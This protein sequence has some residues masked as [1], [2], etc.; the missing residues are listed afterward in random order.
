MTDIKFALRAFAKTPGFTIVVVLTLALGV[1]ATTAIFSVVNAVLLEP[2]PFANA[3]RLVV[4]RVSMPDYKDLRT[5]V[6]AFED[7]GVWGTNIYNLRLK[8]NSEQI[9]GAVVSS[10]LLSLLGVEPLLGRN[11]TAEDGQ[12]N[13]VV[14][15]FGLWQSRFG[16]DP[17]VLGRAIDLS[18]ISYTVVGVA[19]S[20]FSFPASEFKVWVPIDSIDR[21]A[22]VQANNRG[23]R[24]F[25]LLARLKPD[26]TLEQA[27]A[28]V[29]AQSVALGKAYPAT[30]EN[31][32]ITVQSLEE[33]L[34]GESK[35]GLNV[36]LVTV[37]L[38]L[39]IACAN[40]ANLMLART[41]TRER[42]L[43]IRAALGAGRA[44][45][46]RQVLTESLVLAIAG[47]ALGLLVAAWGVDALPALLADRLP[48]A[49]TIRLNG[50]VLGFALAATVITALC[51]G[52]A[53]A[54]HAA[55]GSAG[56][57]KETGR[58]VTGS[59]RGRRLRYAIAVTEVALAVMVIAGSALLVR[60]FLSLSGRDPGIVT[61]DLLSF[62]VQFVVLPDLPARARAAEQVLERVASLPGVTAVG[63]ATG[64]PT[65]TAQRGTRFEVEGRQLTADESGAYFI[66]VTPD[67]FRATQ[68]PVRAG[69][70]IE[71]TDKSGAPAV[72]LISETMA[73]LLFPG[74]D[75]IGKRLRLVNAEQSNEWRTIVGVV[76]D[77][78]FQGLNED[79]GP[80]IY[81]PFAQT[82]FM[83]LYCMVRPATGPI[84][85]SIRSAV[86]S[87]HPSLTAGNLR[88]MED[89][90][91]GTVAEPR[92]RTWLVSS[93]AALALA[94]AA[95]G[96]Y[97]VIAYSVVQRTH[98]IGIRM[99]LG[100]GASDVLRLVVREGVVMAA[101]GAIVGLGASAAMTGLMSSLLVGTTPR[102]PVAFGAA[103]TILLIVA[104]LA[105]YIPARRATRIAPLDALRAE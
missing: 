14:L 38:L 30:N 19:P 85:T 44:R 27:Q 61:K 22:P 79:A 6:T 75:A 45:L 54:L 57:L 50:T 48:R 5:S 87:V 42:E 52:F 93:F 47:G 32:T 23:L 31:V 62:N 34:L 68:T 80:T 10:R 92:F 16:G 84:A 78:R 91:A 24:I 29:T 97:G 94:L 25:N 73:S 82:P 83:W 37:A 95:I 49:D 71:R 58:S 65:V 26:I 56:S 77:I 98:E 59:T 89:V 15:G 8:D 33:R 88:T 74:Q 67:Y 99:A 81:T 63:G 13:T 100:A 46:V 69:R 7:A 96:I 40:V 2:L 12:Q 86:T 20:W 43:A 76:G 72:A 21:L 102:D 28:Q 60:S 64:F 11:F 53:P 104:G 70:A 51:F 103:A 55:G 101:A 18:G 39:L 35:P 90:V 1:G 3:D 36:L 17:S 9:R 105:S 41:T 66:A 4:A